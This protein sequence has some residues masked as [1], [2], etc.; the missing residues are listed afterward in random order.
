MHARYVLGMGRDE[1]DALLEEI[2]EHLVDPRYAYFHAWGRD[3]MIVWDNWR[4][5]HSANGVPSGMRPLRPTY[6][7]HGG[8]QS[9]PLPRRHTQQQRHRAADRGLRK[10]M[11][12]APGP[13]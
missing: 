8:L 2:A 4:V 12:S 10:A 7:Y 6:H 5:I 9:R 1:S 13:R 11:G 3:D